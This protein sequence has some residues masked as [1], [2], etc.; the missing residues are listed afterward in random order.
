MTS[1]NTILKQGYKNYQ[2][3]LSDQAKLEETADDLTVK[4]YRQKKKAIAARL[5]KYAARSI[6]YLLL[7]SLFADMDEMRPQSNTDYL[8]TLESF[9]ASA[10]QM[11]TELMYNSDYS[12]PDY[13]DWA[14]TVL[15]MDYSYHYDLMNI[16]DT[17]AFAESIDDEAGYFANPMQGD[18]LKRECLVT[19]QLIRELMAVT[20]YLPLDEK[21]LA[22]FGK[23]L[24]PD[25][26]A[27]ASR[28]LLRRDDYWSNL[29]ASLELTIESYDS[30]TQTVDEQFDPDGR[31]A[32]ILSYYFDAVD[33]TASLNQGDIVF[34]SNKSVKIDLNDFAL[35][36]K[37]RH[38]SSYNDY[39]Y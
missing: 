7:Q 26:S 4:V 33:Q 10:A 30:E 14:R 24:D 38:T 19:H 18:I 37:L 34:K 6:K 21:E 27:A 20:D 8:M 35:G 5:D 29:K 9:G 31:L 1:K 2:R 12:I 25:V 39:D 32:K 15:T 36:D 11:E 28:A 13:R 17:S 16:Q 3:A 23:R 22:P